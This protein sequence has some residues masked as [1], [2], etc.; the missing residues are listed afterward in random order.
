MTPVLSATRKYEYEER[1]IEG[2]RRLC[3]TCHQL[4][5]RQPLPHNLPRWH[6][7]HEARP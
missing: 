5:R 1:R 3:L 7:R 6:R 2:S 4:L